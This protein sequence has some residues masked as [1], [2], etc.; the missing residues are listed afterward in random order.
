MKLELKVNEDHVFTAETHDTDMVSIEIAF[1]TLVD[2]V[3]AH[4]N[5]PGRHKDLLAA[6]KALNSKED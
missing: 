3:E 2:A 1:R 5:L 4:L 6:V